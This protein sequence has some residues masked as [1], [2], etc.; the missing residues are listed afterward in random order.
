MRDH[1]EMPPPAPRARRARLAFVGVAGLSLACA[2][3]ATSPAPSATAAAAPASCIRVHDLWRRQRAAL[4]RTEGQP[5]DSQVAA[6]VAEAYR[7]YTGFW[8]GYLGDEAAFA[9]WS[10]TRFRLAG[11]PRRDVPDSL[12]LAAEITGATARMAAFARRPVPCSDWYVVYGPGWTN[13]GG[14]G[15]IGMV[16]DLL[17]LRRD[18]PVDD[19]RQTLPHEVAHLIMAAGHAGDSLRGTL[20]HRIVDEGLATYA[21]WAYWKGTLTPAQALGYTD[22][23]WAWALDHEEALWGLAA[24]RLASRERDVIDDFASVSSRP[25]RGAPG[26]IGYFLGFR[27]AEAYAA[28]HGTDAWRDLFTRPLGETLDASGYRPLKRQGS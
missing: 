17:G 5:A 18:A 13:L 12:D 28:R 20:L 6:L 21:A 10:R 15:G 2:A 8:A 3:G 27:I 23:E 1:E 9:D 19:V 7:P 4:A 22:A 26:K 14:L 16:V 25:A 24:P 11:D